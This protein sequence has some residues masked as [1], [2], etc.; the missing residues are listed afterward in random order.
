[1]RRVGVA[2]HHQP[3]VG[4]GD[5]RRRDQPHVPVHERA[6]D[7][8]GPL[9][10]RARRVDHREVGETHEEADV[11]AQREV[12]GSRVAD[13]GGERP[14]AGSVAHP[15]EQLLA[16]PERGVPAHRGP[17]LAVTDHGLAQPVRVVVQ[18]PERGAL[19]AQEAVAPHV[20][21]VGADATHLVAFHLD[22]E[23]AH[24]L[25]ERTGAVVHGA[26]GH[27]VPPVG[28][29]R[30]FAGAGALRQHC[31]RRGALHVIGVAVGRPVSRSPA[32]PR[33]VRGGRGGR[34]GTVG[35]VAQQREEPVHRLVEFGHL[36]GRERAEQLLAGL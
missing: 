5:V 19:R 10:D 16:A 29:D 27:G 1:M 30:P 23:A 18:M 21:A 35:A 22:L 26:G 17:P 25:T 6:R 15:V 28:Q 31:T 11:A 34:R 33:R 32:A 14:G 9:V 24:G 36:I 2:A 20:V 3:V 13:V 7:V 12:V 4:A 8:L